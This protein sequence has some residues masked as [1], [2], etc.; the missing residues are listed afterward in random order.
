MDN[1]FKYDDLAYDVWNSKY[2][3]NGETLDEFFD[4]LANSFNRPLMYHKD[5]SDYGKKR[6]NNSYIE[7]LRTLFRDFKYVIPGG[8]VL[9]GIG[10]DKPVS[11]SNCYVIKTGDSVSEIFDSAKYMANIFKVRGG[12]GLDLS[13]IRPR[14]AL[15]NNAAKTTTGVIPFMELYS[16]TTST[17]GQEG[18]RGALMMSLD[19]RHPDSPEFTTVKR[20]LSKI[21]SANISLRVSKDFMDAVEKDEDYIL[22]WPIDQDLSIFSEDYLAC[23]YNELSQLEDHINGNKVFY[24]KRIK[25]KELWDTIMQSNWLSAEPGILFWDN[26]LDYD[27]AS[28]YDKHRP[29]SVNPCGE[30]SLGPYDSCRLIA[31]N[32][33][34]LVKYPFTKD[35]YINEDLAY[36][37][38]YE[39]QVIADTLVDVELTHIKRIIEL[40][41][42]PEL[43]KEIYNVGYSGRRTGTGLT[44]LGDMYAALGVAYGDPAITENIMRVKMQAELDATIDLAIVYGEFPSY[45]ASLE[46]ELVDG[47]LMGKNK[48]YQF[49]LDEFPTQVARM[50]IYGRR[51]ISISTIAPTGSLS[52]LTGTTSG[53]EPVF[54]LF[55][56]RRRKCNSSETPDF[57]DQNGVGFKNYM[58][59]HPKFREWYKVKYGSELENTSIENLE[60]LA[61]ESPWNNQT[62]NDISPECRINTQSV[63]QKYITHSISSTVNLPENTD[64]D[65]ID[66]LYR[67]GY[68][69]NLKGLTTYRA[70]SRSGILVKIDKEVTK[71]RPDELPCKVLRFKNE[72]RN[73]IA[74]IGIKDGRPYE[75]FTG[76]NDLDELPIPSYIESGSIIKIPTD[77]KSRYDFRYIDNYGYTNTLG[78]LN[79]VFNKEYWNYARFVSALL[80]EGIALENIVNIIEKLEFNNKNLNSWQFGVIRAIKSFIKDGTKTEE[81][82]SECGEKSIVY[83]NGCKICKNCGNSKCG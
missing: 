29:I 19:I 2:R 57:I 78:G 36:T 20:D 75:I 83:E 24:I 56:Q 59:I 1:Y 15:V 79:R 64:V 41:D 54:S 32:L 66:K 76:I 38:F 60:K 18:R 80:R 49:L 62:A 47:K 16:Q 71:D 45:N 34:N 67:L 28:V 13:C 72:K 48:L 65:T 11:L 33:Y 50:S 77:G 61:K 27:L 40:G 74:F 63:L 55:Y 52:I 53:C 44:A 17:I 82:C 68:K 58:V 7:T 30:I 31:V 23:N 69:K 26:M 37:V 10:T 81:V 6:L 8:S 12:V 4:R 46:Y 9:A 39:A 43:W 70:G 14:S 25:A 51:N 73:W 22:R 35:A 3:Q 5:L 21:T 42:E